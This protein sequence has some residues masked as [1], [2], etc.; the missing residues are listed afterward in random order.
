M[1]YLEKNP[2]TK[3]VLSGGQGKGEAVSEAK[4]MYDYLTGHGISGERL[5]LEDRSTNTKENLDFSLKKIGGL[6]KSV[7][8]VTNNF[9]VFR[10]V[11]IGKKCGCRN[12]CGISAR[13]R[14]WRLVIYI[15]REILAVIKDKMM[16]NL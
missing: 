6:N 15:P 11:A 2:D 7:G 8:I 3:A 16:G 13:Y 10:G 1:Q 9:H 14:S 4:A 5:I 12:I